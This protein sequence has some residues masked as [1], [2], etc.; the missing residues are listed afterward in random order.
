MKRKIFIGL[1]AIAMCFV[2]VGCGKTVEDNEEDNVLDTGTTTNNGSDE[3]VK[4]YSDNTKY[5]FEYVNTK[6]VFY[7][8][9]DTITAY[10]TYVDYETAASAKAVYSALKLGDYED[11]DK[12]T[13]KGRYLVFEWN[14]RTYEDMTASD[15]RTAYSYMKEL[16][17]E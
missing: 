5:V 17:E 4:L 16:K 10:H 15:L 1:L 6:Y 7:Y 13:Q 11:L 12:V 14:K 9:G 2:L 3:E 8:S